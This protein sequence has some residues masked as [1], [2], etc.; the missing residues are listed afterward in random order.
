MRKTNSFRTN[1]T[2]GYL[3]YGDGNT[4]AAITSS[5]L[6]RQCVNT[7]RDPRRINTEFRFSLEVHNDSQMACLFG[8]K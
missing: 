3:R 1:E 6:A 4:G 2:S 8:E 5:H 7:R